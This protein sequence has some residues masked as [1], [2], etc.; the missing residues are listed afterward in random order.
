MDFL[1]LLLSDVFKAV[2]SLLTAITVL[3]IL[4]GELHLD[5][6]FFPF[7][8][9]GLQNR[10][11]WMSGQPWMVLSQN[12]KNPTDLNAFCESLEPQQSGEVIQSAEAFFMGGLCKASKAPQDAA[13]QLIISVLLD[14]HLIYN[15]DNRLL[16]ASAWQAAWEKGILLRNPELEAAFQV[17][18]APLD[19]SF[20]SRL[21]IAIQSGDI[22]ENSQLFPVFNAL[23]DLHQKNFRS[24]R[25]HLNELPP[26]N[27][28][29]DELVLLILLKS[30]KRDPLF[31]GHQ[32]LL[33]QIL[34][35]GKSVT[36]LDWVYQFLVEEKNEF[37]L[38][39]QVY[40][41]WQGDQ[42]RRQAGLYLARVYFQKGS[43]SSALRALADLETPL[44]SW[45]WRDLEIAGVLAYRLHLQQKLEETAAA[46]N[47]KQADSFNTLF[48]RALAL[49]LNN[50][51]SE[52]AVI[53][54][55]ARLKNQDLLP[56]VELQLCQIYRVS[57]KFNEAQ[58]CYA[59][60]ALG[61]RNQEKS[62][63][64]GHEVVSASAQRENQQ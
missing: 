40:N 6:N 56:L 36:A 33:N 57:E 15:S 64:L 9:Q 49:A 32:E 12:K 7:N 31:E 19:K 20:W 17:V 2:I 47:L 4:Q 1:K 37:D 35:L 44:P 53:L 54:P 55:K 18:T 48:I 63:R 23:V 13:P 27:Q 5:R 41:G 28:A 61:K 43:N 45:S 29:V 62:M 51:Q 22:S 59:Q 24:L 52:A 11:F 34:R 38:A 8:S 3:V 50:R 60:L 58:I 39:I 42:F 30:Y 14:P 21:G 46:M 26:Q 16:I 25:E 10:F